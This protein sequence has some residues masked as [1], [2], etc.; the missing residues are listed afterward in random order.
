MIKSLIIKLILS[1]NY[2]KVV[3]FI[4]LYLYTNSYN[5][6]REKT[7]TPIID[8]KISII[9]NNF[10]VSLYILEKSSQI[11]NESGLS[12]IICSQSISLNE[13]ENETSLLIMKI[14]HI[15]II[16]EQMIILYLVFMR[17][18]FFIL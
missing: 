4:F 6:N 13:I 7:I 17:I 10:V 15:T 16:I 8:T 5:K 11:T 3:L 12:I 9:R 1:N 18:I 2:S 14:I